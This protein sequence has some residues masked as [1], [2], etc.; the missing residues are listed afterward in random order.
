MIADDLITD[1][2]KDLQ[3]FGVGVFVLLVVLLGLIFQQLKWILIPMLCCFLSVVAM[4]GLLVLFHWDVT[5]ISSNFI[6]LQ[7]IITLAISIHLIVRYNEFLA[8]QPGEQ[9][10]GTRAENRQHEIQPLLVCGVDNHC[11]IQ[12]FAAV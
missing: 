7:L 10:T 12:F 9:S 6:S 8:E 4:M 5:V 1:I 3:L 2:K 11:R